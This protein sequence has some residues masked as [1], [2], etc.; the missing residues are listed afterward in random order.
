ML[1]LAILLTLFTII[2]LVYFLISLMTLHHFLIY[3]YSI[4]FFHLHFQQ[5]SLH[6]LIIPVG[7]PSFIHKIIMMVICY[8]RCPHNDILKI[9]LMNDQLFHMYDTLNDY[10]L[11]HIFLCNF[12]KAQHIQLLFQ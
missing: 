7:L 5:K 10:F 6:H 2:S 12:C 4:H 9:L 11:F 8:G 1:I 3:H